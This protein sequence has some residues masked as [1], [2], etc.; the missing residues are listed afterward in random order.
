MY[1]YE[2][3]ERNVI[4]DM[5]LP[6]DKLTEEQ[7]YIILEPMNAPE[8]YYCDGEITPAQA[9]RRWKQRL[10]DSGLTPIQVALVIK[11]MR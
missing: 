7:I 9:D 3:Y 8:N 4:E 5:G 6:S 11:G 1:N 10:K 2:D